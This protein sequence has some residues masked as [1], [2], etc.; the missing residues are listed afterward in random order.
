MMPSELTRAIDLMV[1]EKGINRDVIIAALEAALLS[2]AKKKYAKRDIEAHFNEEIGE[3]EM[4]E[5]K[6]VVEFPENPYKEIDIKDARR[7]DPDI[8]AGESIGIKMD[9]SDFGRISAQSAKQVL[10]QK[11][12]DAERENIYNEYKDRKGEIIN[13]TVRRFEKKDIIVDLGKTEAILPFK[14][15]VPRENYRAGDRIRAYVKSI[16]RNA[17]THQIILSRTDTGLLIR[18]FEMEVPE[19]YEGIVRIEAAA[20]EPGSRSKIAVASKDMDVDPVGACVGMKGSRVQAVVQ[21]LRNEKI[22]IVTYSPDPAKFVCNALAPAEVSKI[23]IDE[24]DNSMEVV[25][26]D[27]QLSL[28]IGKKGQNVRLAVKLTGWKIDV[29][30]ESSMAQKNIQV[31]NS[32]GSIQGIRSMEIEGLLNNGFQSIAEV[33]QTD[34]KTLIE[35]LGV[36]ADRAEDIL[37]L[38]RNTLDGIGMVESDEPVDARVQIPLG[39]ISGIQPDEMGKLL[40]FGLEFADDLAQKDQETLMM[41][42]GISAARAEELLQLAGARLQAEAPVNDDSEQPEKSADEEV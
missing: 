4:F 6:E 25:V 32:L 11:I 9:M 8:E 36:A 13:G 26:P 27:T 41:M 28:A 34:A 15:Q 35:I 38:A 40:S 19:I 42:L 2:A 39:T 14:F 30:S 37:Q 5:F 33:A 22:D 18:L 12:R 24:D 3:V 23:I 20:R 21:E 17:A 16:E 29:K 7:M 10:N 31:K 1:K